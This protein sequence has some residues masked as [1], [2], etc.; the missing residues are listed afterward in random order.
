MATEDWYIV[1]VKYI[2]TSEAETKLNGFHVVYIGWHAVLMRTKEILWFGN[3]RVAKDYAHF[4]WS[5][6]VS[7]C[8][9]K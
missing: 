6:E 7:K 2:L 5:I 3:R 1:H 9:R 8:I 4:A